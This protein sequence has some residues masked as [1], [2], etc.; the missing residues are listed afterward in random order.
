MTPAERDAAI[1][2]HAAWMA[3]MDRH[4]AASVRR[5]ASALLQR[6][7]NARS[8]AER[9]AWLAAF[10]DLYPLIDRTSLP[11][12]FPSRPR[13]TPSPVLGSVNTK[14]AARH[15]DALAASPRTAG[16]P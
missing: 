3:E 9:D 6:A 10:S 16:A 14:A 2:K 7:A 12:V 11:I 8:D 15:T 4:A 13:P 1:A 5:V